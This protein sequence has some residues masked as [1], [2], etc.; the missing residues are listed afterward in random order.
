MRVPQQFRKEPAM[1]FSPPEARYIKTGCYSSNGDIMDAIMKS[2][3]GNSKGE[4][5]SANIQQN[6]DAPSLSTNISWKNDK[7]MQE[8]RAKFCG[9]MENHGLLI[10]ANLQDPKNILGMTTIIDRQN[11]EQRQKSKSTIDGKFHDDDQQIISVNGCKKTSGIGQLRSMLEVIQC[12]YTSTWLRMRQW[13]THKLRSCDPFPST[14][15][16]QRTNTEER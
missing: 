13:V 2:A 14:A 4:I 8:F 3:T 9:N 5:L 6:E 1:R 11:A 16:L 10:Q 15:F 7:T 12:L